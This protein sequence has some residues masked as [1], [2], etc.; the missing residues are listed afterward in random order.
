MDDHCQKNEEKEPDCIHPNASHFPPFCSVWCYY[1]ITGEVGRL[2]FRVQQLNV[3]VETKTVRKNN[4][5][6]RMGRHE[7][8]CVCFISGMFLS[9]MQHTLFLLRDS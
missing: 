9:H 3:R 8:C 7:R 4:D 5:I 6:L 1:Y 2:S